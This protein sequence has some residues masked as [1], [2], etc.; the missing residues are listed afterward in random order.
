[1]AVAAYHRELTERLAAILGERLLGVYASGSFG[2]TDFDGARSDLDVFAVC[3]PPV[4][5]AEKQ[6]IVAAL[7]HEALPCPARGLEFVLYPEETARVPSAEAGFLLNL[8]TGP[9]IGFRVDEQPG[10]VERHWFPIDRAIVRSSGVALAGPPPQE[11]F[12]PIPRALLLPVVRESLE[13]HRAPGNCG[14]DDAVLNACRS[15]RWLR[16][17]VWSSK[18]EAG[19]WALEHVDDPGLVAEALASRNRS[20]R[21]DRERVV[22]LVDG[23]LAELL[24]EP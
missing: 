8:N 15:L 20:A 9:Q 24:C 17:D 5:S 21:L 2:L 10:A 11:L 23:V 18:S 13:W 22:R 6:A 19:A 12:A 1:M 7:R 14:D 4:T 3:R 16:E